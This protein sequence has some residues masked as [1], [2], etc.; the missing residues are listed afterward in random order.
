MKHTHL[1]NHGAD[2]GATQA[3][4]PYAEPETKEVELGQEDVPPGSVFRPIGWSGM[5]NAHVNY[6]AVVTNG[7][8]TIGREWGDF[9][10][11]YGYLP[12]SELKNDWQINRS[13]SEG[14]WNPDAWEPCK[15]TITVE[16]P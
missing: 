2:I 8:R 3:P 12:W 15:K 6:E 1:T 4:D 14:Q 10:S 13:L 5:P 16:Q 7:V 11:E 9:C